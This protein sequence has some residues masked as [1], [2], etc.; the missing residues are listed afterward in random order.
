MESKAKLERRIKTLEKQVKALKELA[1]RSCPICAAR[2]QMALDERERTG[3][4]RGC[5]GGPGY[6]D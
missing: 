3:W 6:D 1:N 2:G 5:F 4:I